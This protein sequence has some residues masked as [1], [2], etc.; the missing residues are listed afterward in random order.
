MSDLDGSDMEEELFLAPGSVTQHKQLARVAVKIPPFFRRNVKTWFWQIEAQFAN[1]NIVSELT[2]YYYV[3]GSLDSDIAEQVADFMDKPLSKSPYSDLKTRLL[4]EF[5]D[6]Q[7]KKAKKLLNEIQLGDR[8][9]SVLL[10]E[11]R[12]LAGDNLKDDFLQM[13]FL[14]RLPEPTKTILAASSNVKL[15]DLAAMADRILEVTP[16]QQICSTSS[17]PPTAP[18]ID[19]R[20]SSLEALVKNM[21]IN[22]SELT[23]RGRSQTRSQSPFPRRRS[24]SKHELCWYHFRF[25]KAATKCIQPCKFVDSDKGNH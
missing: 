21:A 7:V 19:S 13:I 2:K 15:D 4:A 20:L 10:R 1:S 11:M 12:V 8:K 18:D 22:I 25:G 3:V 9:P 17:N 24:S 23:T 14:D 5:G 16:T 6:S